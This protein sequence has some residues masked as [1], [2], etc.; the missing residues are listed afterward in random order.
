MKEFKRCSNIRA[1][2][3]VS[4]L[5]I[6]C[7]SAPEKKN[8][9]PAREVSSPEKK[10][11]IELRDTTINFKRKGADVQAHYYN[12]T[13]SN[14]LNIG[15]IVLLPGWN[16]SS[17]EWC[18]KTT[19]CEKARSLGYNLILVDMS[20]SL[21]ALEVH[22]ET[23]ADMKK[24]AT[25][26]WFMDTLIPYFQSNFKLLKEGDNNYVLGLSTGGRGAALLCLD[27]PKI[28]KKGAALSGDFNQES[29][30]KDN[31]TRIFYGS[32]SSFKERWIGLDNVVYNIDRFEVPMYLGHGLKD[33]V[34]YTII[35]MI[36]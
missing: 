16:Y 32:Y 3:L 17:K 7:T 27:K 18:T 36:H 24:Y 33:K 34:G 22:K 19:F 28:F 4:I 26:Q 1:L 15:T 31:L 8:T 2:F 10:P 20:K 6:A 14:G 29:I 9:N 35:K 5:L 21:Y 25:R 12:H 23:R 13:D 11:P 30:P